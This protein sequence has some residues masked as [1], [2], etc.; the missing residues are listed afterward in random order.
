M[1]LLLTFL[2]LIA[3]YLNITAN[4]LVFM[5]SYTEYLTFSLTILTFTFILKFK[6]RK[7]ADI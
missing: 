7:L 5:L 6:T 1:N 2:F 4:F 3:H